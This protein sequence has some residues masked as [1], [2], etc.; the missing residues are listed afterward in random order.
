MDTSQKRQ[1]ARLH[2]NRTTRYNRLRT[3]EQS[4]VI[5]HRKRTRNQQLEHTAASSPKNQERFLQ[6]AQE[7]KMKNVAYGNQ[8]KTLD[9]KIANYERT[10]QVTLD[11]EG[12]AIV[13]TEGGMIN[14]Q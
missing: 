4:R 12:G 1:M 14:R 5:Q 7:A 3:K 11:N 13:C 2:E 8:L 9:K 10:W 6:L